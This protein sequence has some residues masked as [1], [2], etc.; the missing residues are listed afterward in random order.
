MPFSRANLVVLGM[1]MVASGMTLL[2]LGGW[3]LYATATAEIP[4]D[5]K[6]PDIGGGILSLFTAITGLLWLLCIGCH[7]AVGSIRRP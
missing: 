7:L 5:P 6:D 2:C 3:I 1:V 4:I